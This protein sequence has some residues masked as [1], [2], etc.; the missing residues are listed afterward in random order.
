[1]YAVIERHRPTLFSSVPTGY[2]MLLAHP[3]T[4]DLSSVRLAV[5]AGEAL[6]PTLYDRFKQRFGVDILDGIGSTEGYPCSSRTGPM[7]SVPARAV[8]SSRAMKPRYSTNRRPVTRGEIGNLGGDSICA[9]YWNQHEKTKAT[10]EGEWIRTGDRY[11]QDADGFTGRRTQRRH[12]EIGGHG[13][14]DRGGERAGRATRCRTAGSSAA[15]IATRSSPMA[16]VVPRAGVEEQQATEL[17]QFVRRSWPTISGRAGEFVADLPRTA[18]ALQTAPARQRRARGHV[19]NRHVIRFKTL[20]AATRRRECWL[21]T[22]RRQILNGPFLI[23]RSNVTS[24][25][26]VA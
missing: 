5:S 10:I 2:G 8:S 22:R 1:M 12:A 9:A 21:L 4:F 11:T 3:G 24:E 25:V 19:V 20:A 14:P 16:Y 18:T 6:P 26:P 15:R 13:W 17:E 7:S 23:C